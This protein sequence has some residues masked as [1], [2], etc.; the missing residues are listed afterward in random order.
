MARKVVREI[1]R[2]PEAET[3]VVHEHYGNGNN[4]LGVIVGVIV[5]IVVLF[6]VLYYGLPYL[7]GSMSPQVNIPSQIDVNVK[8]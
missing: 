8:K 3:P 1:V 2:E 7:R 6:L 4:G 5:L